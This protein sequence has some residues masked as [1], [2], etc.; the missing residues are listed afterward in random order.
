MCERKCN[1]DELLMFLVMLRIRIDD[2]P[3][4]EI[5]LGL[6]YWALNDGRQVDPCF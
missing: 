4:L 1:T 6:A 3:R 2:F 5:S